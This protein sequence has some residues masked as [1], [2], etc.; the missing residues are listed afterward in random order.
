MKMRV[1]L[2]AIFLLG[3]AG[4]A[5]AQLRELACAGAWT[6]Y[7]GRS[8]SGIP[9]CSMEVRNSHS[10]MHFKYFRG[11]N[12]IVVHVFKDNWRLNPGERV[13]IDLRIDSQPGW[14]A[15]TTVL[16]DGRG[17]EFTIPQN[18]IPRFENAFR[19][20]ITMYL[21]FPL[22]GESTW[23]VSLRGTNA[24]TSAFVECMRIV[25]RS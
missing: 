3:S 4:I 23:T 21:A 2:A 6:M 11:D 19:M 7:G 15:R 16:R 13:P 12:R 14:N 5:H 1:V 25:N 24:V 20:G 18:E 10:S 17:L 9:M 8:E 22:G